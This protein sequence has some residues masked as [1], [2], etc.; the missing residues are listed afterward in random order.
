MGRRPGI[1]E[2]EWE[3]WKETIERIYMVEQQT[4]KVLIKGMASTHGFIATEKQYR[5][6]LEKWGFWKNNTQRNPSATV[7]RGSDH[8]RTRAAQALP[9]N[10]QRPTL[11][12]QPYRHQPSPEF[13]WSDNMEQQLWKMQIAIDT[14]IKG[15]FGSTNEKWESDGITI[16]APT[17]V[18]DNSQNWQRL[19][20]QCSAFVAL[21]GVG[22]HRHLRAALQQLMQDTKE[23]KSV[24]SPKAFIF[25]LIY[26]WKMCLELLKPRLPLPRLK[27]A[28][29]QSHLSLNPIVPT[30]V[31][32]WEKRLAKKLGKRDPT[33]D[34]MA[35][36]LAIFRSSPEKLKM[37]LEHGT[38]NPARVED[39]ALEVRQRAKA[40]LRASSSCDYDLAAVEAYVFST[41][42]LAKKLYQ[43]ANLS[44]SLELLDE[45]IDLL[46]YGSTGCLIWAAMFSKNRLR[47]LEDDKAPRPSKP[48]KH[49]MLELRAK[50]PMIQVANYDQPLGWSGT[51]ERIRF[52]RLRRKTAKGEMFEDLQSM[53]DDLKLS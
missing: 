7:N 53:L 48:E 20:S 52:L 49:R 1:P 19:N 14:I 2:K 24:F 17:S 15:S 38:S 27:T 31:D 33:C 34:I 47:L 32:Q 44:F 30:F 50:L 6:R 45:A 41:N 28:D 3:K 39:F 18:L 36:L 35:A 16:T 10:E 40:N 46:K 23:V 5:N 11:D 43:R 22:L 8:P 12:L 25:Q 29:G 42:L 37:G 51:S 9:S 21:S 13:R 4:L 26:M